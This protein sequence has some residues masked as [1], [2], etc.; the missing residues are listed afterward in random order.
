MSEKANGQMNIVG[1]RNFNKNNSLTSS[2]DV[3]K[4]SGFSVQGW[5]SLWETKCNFMMFQAIRNSLEHI[6]LFDKCS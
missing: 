4:L 2:L 5:G 6:H 1:L 3:F